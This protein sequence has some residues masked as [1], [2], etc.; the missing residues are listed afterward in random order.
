MTYFR[1]IPVDL[2]VSITVLHVLTMLLCTVGIAMGYGNLCW[3]ELVFSTSSFWSGKYWTLF[4]DIFYHNIATE[5]IWFLVSIALFCW[6]GRDVE[7]F[8]GRLHFAVLYLALMVV[9]PLVCLAAAHVLKLHDLSV[10]L[11]YIWQFSIFVGFAVIYPN[12]MLL[13][14]IKVKWEALALVAVFG[15][16][17]LAFLSQPGQSRYA[18][19]P[20]CASLATVYLYLRF[21]G[22]G[23]GIG[24]WEWFESWRQ[25]RAERGFIRRREAYENKVRHQEETV[26][27]ILEKIS[28]SGLSSLTPQER[29]ILEKASHQLSQRE[30]F[31]R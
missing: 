6:F 16:V 14:G 11:P 19:I 29:I 3:S 9:P 28:C 30:K 24:F 12:V 22:V 21:V 31:P 13:P 7:R 18:L 10:H 26:D 25:Q 23:N 17:L 2:T 27:G 1:G 5:H 20:Y 8:I 4:T 15:L